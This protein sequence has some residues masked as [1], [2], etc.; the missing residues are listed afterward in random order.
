[1]AGTSGS[2]PTSPQRTGASS[3]FA[4][5]GA[6]GRPSSGFSSS[7]SGAGLLQPGLAADVTVFDKARVQSHCTIKGP[8]AYAGGVVH[9]LVNGR[10]AMRDGT[11]TEV[12]NGS[13][14]RP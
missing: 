9:V 2:I 14:L 13:V 11:R 3:R 6:A 4:I 8:R 1:M 5:P 12:D 10:F 7:A